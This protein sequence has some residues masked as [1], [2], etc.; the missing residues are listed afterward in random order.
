MSSC[1]PAVEL[2]RDLIRIPSQNPGNT[3]RRIAEFIAEYFKRIGI[4]S[5]FIEYKPERTN[6]IAEIPSKNGKARVLLS[7]HIDTVP[8]GDG[9]CCDPFAAEIKAGKIY[10][11]GAADCKINA[12]VAMDV[13]RRLKAGEFTLDNIDLVFA[14]S[15]EEETGSAIGFIPL[16]K[17]IPFCKYS[18][19]L[20]G[21]DFEIGYAQKG[22][23]HMEV[24]ALGKKAHGAYPEEGINAAD[25]VIAFYEEAKKFVAGANKKQKKIEMT[26]NLGVLKGGNKVNMVPD[27]CMAAL[28]F[29]F[30]PPMSIKEVRDTLKSIAKKLGGKFTFHELNSQKPACYPTDGTLASCMKS[31]L[32]KNKKKVVYKL[33]KGATV[34]N[35]SHKGSEA[36]ILGFAQ[37]GVFHK[38][39]ECVTVK[40]VDEGVKVLRDILIELDKKV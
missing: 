40:S 39:D 9:W 16:V 37:P 21:E 23:V 17:E 22:V 19:I 11:R 13:I 31:A 8:A 12:A 36:L 14:G 33:F 25:R 4:A 32:L 1:S 28:D 26:L 27:E 18:L 6:V 30:L 35:Y 10:G 24:T 5:K 38:T 2:L 34:L 29:R 20:D 7:P 15:A 3:E